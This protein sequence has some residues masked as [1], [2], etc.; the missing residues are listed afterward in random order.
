MCKFI[1]HSLFIIVMVWSIKTTHAQKLEYPLCPKHTVTDTFFNKYVVSENYRWLENVRNDSILNWV[2]QENKLAKKYLQK[3]S[4]KYNCKTLID[5]YDYVIMDFPVKDGKYYFC[6]KRRNDF[7]TAGLYMG[8]SPKNIDQLLID[9]NYSRK[10]DKVNIEG[11]S[12][13]KNSKHLAYT[14]SRNGSDWREIRTIALPSGSEMK[15]HLTGV[16]FSAI[17]WRGDGFYYSRY[18]NL[19]EFYAT[20][21]EEIYYHKLGEPQEKDQLIF[22]RKNPKVQFSY[23][24][25]SDERFFILREKTKYYYNYFFIDFHSEKP[26]LRP[27]LMK[28]KSA[29]SFV[30]NYNGKLIATSGKNT[31]GGMVVEIDPFNPTKW[32]LV[33]PEVNNAVLTDCIAKRD[34]ILLIYQSNQHPLLKVY[35]IAGKPLY[36]LALPDASSIYG[37]NG[38]KDDEEVYFFMERYTIPPLP[39]IFNTKTFERRFGETVQVTYN[40]KNYEHKSMM[41]PINDSIRVPMNIVYKKGLKLNGDNP[42]LLKV[43]GGFGSI[44]SPRFDAGI[45]YFIEQGGVFAYA[46]VRGSGDLGKEW[47]KAGRGLN[48]QNTI[49]DVHSAAEYLIKEGYTTQKKIAIN[50]A[51]HGGLIVAAAAIQRPDLYAAVVPDVA[52]TDMLRFENF[53]VGSIHTNEFGTV[54]DSLDFMNLRSYSPLHNIKEDVNYPAMLIMTAENDD[55]VPPFHSYKFVAELQNREAQLN[56]ILLRVEKKAGHYGGINHVS[57]IREKADMYGFLMKIL[58]R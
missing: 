38:E 10:G 22:K 17:A 15:D 29:I 46:N 35:N 3:A 5:K 47:I 24:M 30:D 53:T 8:S 54:T 23:Q 12:V 25:T 51:S 49:D 32:R 44:S 6:K 14:I 43:Y 11:Y 52:V 26:Y 40:F 58:S 21:G 48:K 1:S 56:P 20:I 2:E 41:Y 33:V 13:S 28:Q 57:I 37:F 55:R 50:G 19:G 39:Y 7:A 42:C 18:P 4:A 16:K 9:P 34:R 36:S 27:L 45:I 31:N